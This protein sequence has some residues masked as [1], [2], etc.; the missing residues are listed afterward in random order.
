MGKN[1]SDALKD[2]IPPM[3]RAVARALEGR[4]LM[5]I[6]VPEAAGGR[7]SSWLHRAPQNRAE[8]P[9]RTASQDQAAQQ[10]SAGVAG[11]RTAAV[12]ELHGGGFALGDVR[13]GDALRTWIAHRYG[14]NV[15]GVGYR[16]APE[17]PWPAALDDVIE[18]LEYFAGH[19][20]EYG[21]DPDAFYLV[22]YSAGANLA[23]AT[24]LKL[25]ERDDLAFRIRGMAL[26]YP[27]LDAA[28]DPASLGTGGE[29]IPAEMMEAFNRWYAVDNDPRNPLIS[30]LFASDGQLAALPRVVQYPV[31]G[32]A[33]RPS[34]EALH[35]R[36]AAAGCDCSL[37]VVEGAYHG[38]IEDAENLAVYRATSLPETGAARPSGFAQVAAESMAE[39]LDALLGRPVSDVPFRPDRADE[40]ARAFAADAAGEV[41]R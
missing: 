6:E 36:L 23:L 8:A 40:D 28:V 24:C 12:F 5:G 21:M 9:D 31:A 7:I 27:F 10:G 1:G 38:Y 4:P 37:Q 34:A 33:L 17:H 30:P 2:I 35:A 29:D 41:R 26:H 14:V 39:S 19:A 13:K 3:R 32:D 18:T 15:V 20:D 11:G 22:G 16:L 25:Q